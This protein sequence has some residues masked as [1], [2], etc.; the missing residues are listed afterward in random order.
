[1]ELLARL[2]GELT[3]QAQ[4]TTITQVN[5]HGDPNWPAVRQLVFDVL[6]PNPELVERFR[7]GLRAL[8]S[9]IT[10]RGEAP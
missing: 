2:R 8:A 1:V 3:S 4:T 9:S 10:N 6:S 5:F 7:E